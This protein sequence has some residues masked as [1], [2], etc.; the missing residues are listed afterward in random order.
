MLGVTVLIGSVYM[1]VLPRFAQPMLE[2]VLAGIDDVKAGSLLAA[3]AILFFPVTFLGMYSPFAIRLLLRSAHAPAR[4]PA[5]STASP[6]S[7][8]S[9]A[10]SAPPSF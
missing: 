9:S 10:R 5:R 4:S 7:A 2:L 1:L 8:A 6:P 3:F